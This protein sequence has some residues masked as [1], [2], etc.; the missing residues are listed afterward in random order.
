MNTS[1]IR[2]SLLV[3]LLVAVVIFSGCSKPKQEEVK[4]ETS[5]EIAATAADSE[6]PSLQEEYELPGEYAIDLS[7][8][9]MALTFYL[10]IDEENNFLL[11]ANKFFSDDRGSGVIGELEG[12]YMMIYS[13]STPDRTK[14]ATFE[15]VGHNLLFQT[16]L[17]YGS[18]NILFELE[19]EDD[20]ELVHRLMADKF[21][22]EE[23]YNTYLGFS[24]DDGIEYAY[25]LQTGPGARYSFSSN[26][27]EEDGAFT[28]SEHGLFKVRGE[29][30]ILIPEEDVELAGSITADGGLL[31]PVKSTEA[32]ERAE[33][34]LRV[35]ITAKNAGTWY[36]LTL[37][38][39]EEVAG[40]LVLDYFG[41]YT[42]TAK[43]PKGD[44]IE[45]GVFEP[46]QDSISFTAAKE[47]ATP[48]VAA[49]ENYTL[50]TSF[51][52]AHEGP[53]AEWLFYDEAVQGRFSGST[54]AAEAYRAVLDLT[55]DS[56]YELTVIDEQNDGTIL[57][58]QA[59]DF[60]VSVSPMAFMIT[61]TSDD[62]EVSVGQIWP[63][64]LNMTIEVI[65]DNYSFLLTK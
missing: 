52:L 20:P 44:Y 15:R 14:T 33:Q 53:Q 49:K 10:R 63:T 55:P 26:Y 64:G 9:G 32:G 4:T 27:E 28:F 17:P 13:D 19:D 7:N 18:A 36:G 58:E 29:T 42:F 50:K 51:N 11:S 1:S 59:G 38:D 8:L 30:M 23:Y 31:L 37:V 57:I 40:E 48:V 65:D 16:P 24:E 47:G 5:K 25:T 60:A 3:L 46:A 12:T 43:N 22:Y 41:G 39:G 61:L 62:S 54:M 34:L 45:Q 56:R 6:A 35:A 21:V 2:R